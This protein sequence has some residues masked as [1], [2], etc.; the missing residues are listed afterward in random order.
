MKEQATQRPPAVDPGEAP[1]GEIPAS[2]Y[3]SSH[4]LRE[5]FSRDNAERRRQSA[6][7]LRKYL[8]AAQ[9]KKVMNKMVRIRDEYEVANNDDVIVAWVQQ[10][11]A[12][13]GGDDIHPKLIEVAAHATIPKRDGPAYPEE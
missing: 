4:D 2:V 5:M 3:Y 7:T 9:D 12:E 11:L 1:E 6:K 13:G 10:E 8:T